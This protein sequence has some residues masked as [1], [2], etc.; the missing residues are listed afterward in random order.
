MPRRASRAAGENTMTKLMPS[1]CQSTV[2]GYGL[3]SGTTIS[4]IVL[5]PGIAGIDP[6]KPVQTSHLPALPH[7]PSW[8]GGLQGD[9]VMS[10]STSV[11]II[12]V[13]GLAILPGLAHSKAIIAD[14]G[15]CGQWFRSIADSDS[16]RSR[17]AF[18]W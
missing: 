7:G 16:D 18:R 6:G 15:E 12:A 11:T 9:R 17:T 14:S 10:N 3:A 8:S 13:I 2:R 4:E 1:D 5:P